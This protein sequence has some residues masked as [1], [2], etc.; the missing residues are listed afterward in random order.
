MYIKLNHIGLNLIKLDQIEKIEK[1]RHGLGLNLIL[2][3]RGLRLT[4]NLVKKNQLHINLNS[5]LFITVMIRRLEGNNE[6]QFLENIQF[7]IE[8][9]NE[10]SA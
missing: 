2:K 6:V 10:G 7:Y 3:T 1:K 9:N 5:Y 8:G 4:L